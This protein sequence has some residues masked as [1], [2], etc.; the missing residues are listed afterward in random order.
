MPG[1]V[2]EVLGRDPIVVA[3]EVVNDSKDEARRKEAKTRVDFYCD[4]IEGHLQNLVLDVFLKD[5][6]RKRL[7]P[8]IPAAAGV[9]VFKRLVDEIARPAYSCPPRRK[10]DGDEAGVYATIRKQCDFDSKMDIAARLT[11]A[12]N[13]TRLYFRANERLGLIMQVL[14]QDQTSAIP[15][16]DDPLRELALIFDCQDKEW[17]RYWDREVTFEFHKGGAERSGSRKETNGL[18]PFV[19]I[20]RRGRWA[21][22][23]DC[24]SGNDRV[25]LQLAVSL[26][27]MLA[28]KLHKSQGFRQPTVSGDVVGMPKGQSL[29]EESI[30]VAPAGATISTLDLKSDAT[31][32]MDTLKTLV[33]MTASNYGISRERMNQQARAG[34]SDAGLIERRQDI[35]RVFRKAEQDVF[36]TIKAVSQSFD[37]PKWRVPLNAE[38]KQVDFAELSDGADMSAL[39]DIWQ[40]QQAM[41]LR[42]PLQNIMALNPEIATETEAAAVLA[43]NIAVNSQWIDVLRGMNMSQDADFNGGGQTP[44]ENGKMGPKV[45]DGEMARDEAAKR[46]AG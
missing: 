42:T 33:D 28:L 22:M 1:G 30:L 34:T 40:K 4:R 9:N 26:L 29:D 21:V 6:V 45:R 25:R 41:A 27:I 7:E 39:L 3:R 15:D 37:N 13:S 12:A 23:D 17:Y 16:P 8:F 24:Q 35:I 10:V 38:L 5:E 46:A 36:E 18:W 11:E 2:E 31:H 32:Y 44:E 19:S 20:H 43:D 14:S